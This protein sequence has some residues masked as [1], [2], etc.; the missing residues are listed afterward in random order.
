MK[1]FGLFILNGQ[2]KLGDIGVVAYGNGQREHW[3]VNAG[4]PT[5]VFGGGNC[6]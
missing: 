2:L 5:P 6:G 3:N 4:S 1:D